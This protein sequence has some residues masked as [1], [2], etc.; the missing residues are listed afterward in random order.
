MGWGLSG[1]YLP[2]IVFDVRMACSLLDSLRPRFAESKVG[3]NKFVKLFRETGF[4]LKKLGVESK[5]GFLTCPRQFH[6]NFRKN[7]ALTA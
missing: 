6:K 5:R 1:S 3:E 4:V 2:E 7:V